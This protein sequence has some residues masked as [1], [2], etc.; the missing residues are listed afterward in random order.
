MRYVVVLKFTL[1][2]KSKAVN[3]QR[4]TFRTINFQ[5]IPCEILEKD[6][7]PAY[8]WRIGTTDKPAR[9]VREE[10]FVLSVLPFPAGFVIYLWNLRAQIPPL[11]ESGAGCGWGALKRNLLEAKQGHALLCPPQPLLSKERLFLVEFRLRKGDLR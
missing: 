1:A 11:G 4:E 8:K 6:Q 2:L 10:C 7:E 3:T 9:R 5:K